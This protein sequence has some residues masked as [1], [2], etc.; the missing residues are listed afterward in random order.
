MAVVLIA[1]GTGLV[2]RALSQMLADKG[3]EII[4]LT[5]SS[6]GKTSGSFEKASW[7]PDKGT[8]DV[9][10]VQRAD[11]IVNLAG[12]GVADKRWSKKRKQEILNSRV[13]SGQ[14]I[15]KALKEHPNKVK[16]V[17]QASAMGWYGEDSRLKG[18]ESFSEEVSAASDFFGQ[19]CQ[20]WEQ[21]IE[22]VAVLGKR[23]VILRIGLV[24]DK[25]G[26]AFKEFV[27]PLKAGIAAILGNGTQ[28]QSW[29]H[30]KDLCRMFVFAIENVELNGVYNAVA[31]KPVNNK[32]L[33]TK[34]A[35]QLK[36]SF[37]IPVNVPAFVLKMAVGEM[38]SE[39][40]KSINVSAERMRNA[41][42]QFV[43]PS[44]ESALVDLTKK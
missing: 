39:L 27:R 43:F 28:M 42:F 12:A 29:I 17:I 31:P 3:Y 4:V 8:I 32:T 16:A 30:V 41:G 36:G 23:L 37:Y 19:T 10:A 25:G 1:G 5:R 2:G 20:A 34:I 24:L 21:S 33:I 35:Q 44:L 15:A 22:P 11:Y 13:L 18:E 26:G 7:N 40:L 14:L 9:E 38:S 6:K